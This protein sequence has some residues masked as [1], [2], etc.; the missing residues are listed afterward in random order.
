MTACDFSVCFCRYNAFE[1]YGMLIPHEEALVRGDLVF[2]H[3][4][5]DVLAFISI[6][7]TIFFSHQWLSYDIPDPEGVHY[8]AIKD[9]AEK[10]VERHQLTKDSLYIW[11]GT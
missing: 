10:V 8:A 2:L 11:I 7:P 5:Q 1:K 3:T 6:F 4:Y 9:A